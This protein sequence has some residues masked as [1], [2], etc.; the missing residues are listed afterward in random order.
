M[1]SAMPRARLLAVLSAALAVVIG[2]SAWGMHYPQDWWL[3]NICVALGLVYLAA[4][5]RGCPL[6]NA[7]YVVVF[8]YFCLHEVGA[9]WTYSE[10]PYNDWWRGLFG[11]TLNE[12]LGWQRNHYDRFLHFI[13][14]FLITHP[15]REQIL[16]PVRARGFWSYALP[17]VLLT[18]TSTAY[19]LIEWAAA[20]VFGGDLGMAYLGTQGDVWDAQRDTALATLGSILAMLLAARIN[21][22]R[23]RDAAAEFAER[24]VRERAA[25]ARP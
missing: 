1:L 4:T 7:S 3:E 10:V 16:Q 17:V 6:S 22:W 18:F 2:L 13:Y 11:V 14:G 23:G 24:T 25:T 8:A 21:R 19:E 9:H 12:L 20:V 5:A 15:M